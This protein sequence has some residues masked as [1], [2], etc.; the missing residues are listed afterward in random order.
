MNPKLLPN[1]L[2][3]IERNLVDW[4]PMGV[5]DLAVDSPAYCLFVWYQDFSGDYTPHIGVATQKLLDAIESIPFTDPDDKFDM[6]WRPQQTADLDVPGRLLLDEC[7]IV[8]NEVENCYEILAERSGLFH[9]VEDS[10]DDDDDDDDDEPEDEL[11]GDGEEADDIDEVIDQEFS[12]L[13]PF[14]EMMHRVGKKLAAYNWSQV[15]PIT[16]NFVVLVGDYVGYWLAD[17]FEECVDQKVLTKLIETGL[18]RPFDD[19]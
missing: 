7:D 13:A 18:L 5:K 11:L 4:I 14:R 16:D 1:L 19:E 17:D 12:T 6:I 10:D 8:E 9:E 15:M 2:Q 3:S